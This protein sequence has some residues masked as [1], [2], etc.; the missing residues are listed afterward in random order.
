MARPTSDDEVRKW[1]SD[2]L[3]FAE[4]STGSK[5][6]DG[7]LNWLRESSPQWAGRYN[8]HSTLI[9]RRALPNTTSAEVARIQVQKALNALD[10]KLA[11]FN[12]DHGTSWTIER[13][14]GKGL[15][16]AQQYEQQ[17]PNQSALERRIETLENRIAELQERIAELEPSE[18]TEGLS[19]IAF[20]KKALDLLRGSQKISSRSVDRRRI[21]DG[22]AVESPPAQRKR[23]TQSLLSKRR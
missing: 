16:L 19:Q 10:K 20:I 22:D 2:L 3:T 4:F 12:E 7:V 14:K 21:G 1:E 5:I 8:L 9:E 17:I 15:R 23:T 11:Q 18:D 13:R 6:Q